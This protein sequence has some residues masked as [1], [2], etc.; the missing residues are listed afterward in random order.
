VRSSR[1]VPRER[2]ASL[3]EVRA[4][5]E[6][7][8][9]ADLLRLE[10]YAAWRVQGLG[11]KAAGR[12]HEDLLNDAI[13]ATLD[14]V[15]S[16]NKDSVNFVG[17][18]IGTMRSIST[19]WG[20]RFKASEPVLE[21]ELIAGDA[22]GAPGPLDYVAHDEPSAEEALIAR[23][24]RE[25]IDRFFESDALVHLILC[26]LQE[27]GKLKEIRDRYELTAA[28]FEAALKRLRRHVA[29]YYSEKSNGR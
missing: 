9:D 11:R 28:E 18:L 3:A 19:N 5:I 17:F 22:P 10:G 21:S 20:N 15:R 12:T 1:R 7:L 26:E 29:Q 25:A 8:T 2:A 14:G 4:A 27:G 6:A 13:H 16:W 23:E 24:H